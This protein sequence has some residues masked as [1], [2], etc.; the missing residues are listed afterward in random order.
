MAVISGN[1]LLDD[2]VV[3]IIRPI[4]RGEDGIEFPFTVSD[5]HLFLMGKRQFQ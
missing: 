1:E 5:E 3:L 2:Q 4:D